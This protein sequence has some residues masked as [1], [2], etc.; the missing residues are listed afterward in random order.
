M[1]K[2]YCK[3]RAASHT[4]ATWNIGNG[5]DLNTLDIKIFQDSSKN[6]VLKFVH[7]V[8]R[9]GLGILTANF[10]SFEK[11]VRADVHVLIDCSAQYGA[12]FLAKETL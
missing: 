12:F 2:A 10:I 8:H 6:G 3:A 1:K 4:C 11:F 5:A 9:F 7:I